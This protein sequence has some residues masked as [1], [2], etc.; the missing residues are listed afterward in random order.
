[1][2]RQ[3]RADL[4]LLA[5]AAIWG[6]TF[7]MVRQAVA[8]IGPFTFL[9]LRFALAA[10]LLALLF[11]GRLRRAGRRTWAAGML[12]GLFLFAGY[13]LQTVGLRYT[14]A[15]RAGF[16]TGL[17]VVLVPFVAWAWLRRPPGL[18]PFGGVVLAL[19]GLALLAWRPGEPLAMQQGDWLVVGCAAAFALHIVALGAYAPH[20]D[21]RALALVQIATAAGLALGAALWLERPG[22]VA[23][24]PPAAV[25]GAA[26]FTGLFATAVA[27]AV[28]STA[29][30]HTT[31]THVAV[32]FATE[33]VFAVIAGVVLA[34]EVFSV[35]AWAGCAL[36]LAGMLVAELWPRGGSPQ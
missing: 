3:R 23:G 6:A 24:P 32:I 18:G 21:A 7:V 15:G 25:L 12:V 16:L 26:A 14:T 1:M 31:P 28:Q 34:G 36:I 27:F 22:L 4:A 33:P 13:A 9:A 10:G 2:S 8:L 30:A 20:L 29:Q 11:G 17:A 19:G 35:A 5:V